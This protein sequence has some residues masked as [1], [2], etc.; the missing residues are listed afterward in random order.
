MFNII[1]RLLLLCLKLISNFFQSLTTF[2]CS[3]EEDDDRCPLLS[4]TTT[5]ATSSMTS[6]SAHSN[7]SHNNNNNYNHKHHQTNNGYSRQPHQ[8]P[9]A[10]VTHLKSEH[11]TNGFYTTT[12][13]TVNGFL[14]SNG[15][16][17]GDAKP[18]GHHH[19]QHI[20]YHRQQIYSRP[21][22]PFGMYISNLICHGTLFAFGFLNDFLRGLGW[23]TSIE[24][25]ER[26]RPGYTKLYS[27]FTTFYVR[28]IIQRLVRMW[29]HPICSVPGAITEILERRFTSYNASWK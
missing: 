8:P 27:S 28:N 29:S 22:I 14:H 7:Q 21:T 25:V 9:A 2:G 6:A 17:N 3:E 15:H 24:Y 19:H 11:Y 16:S 1:A 4:S 10:A 26:N 23:L 18:N 12:N 20:E 13:G 5:A